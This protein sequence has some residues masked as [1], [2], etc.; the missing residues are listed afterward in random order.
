MLTFFN[1]RLSEDSTVSI[2]EPIKKQNLKTF[3]S[4][5][6][7]KVTKVKDRTIP[8]KAQSDLFGWLAVIMQSRKINLEE[9]FEYPLGPHPWPLTNLTGGLRKTN[10]AALLHKLEKGVD[11]VERDT[12]TSV[13]TII[14]GMAM[15]QKAKTTGLTYEALAKQ[16]LLSVLSSGKSSNR[17]DVVFDQYK[18]RSIKNTERERRGNGQLVVQSIVTTHP[19]QQ[20]GSFLSSWSN[21]KELIR[22]VV[23]QW[24]QESWRSLISEGTMLYVAH[25]SEC[26]CLTCLSVEPVPELCS[27][28]E[29]ADTKM[30]LHAKHASTNGLENILIQSPDTDVFIIALSCLST[31]E[32]NIFFETG[33]RD[34]RRI[35]NLNAIKDALGLK[36]PDHCAYTIDYLLASLLGLHSF[37]GCDS[38]SAFA[39][40]GKA[41][42]LNIMMQS[43]EF[44]TLFSNFGNIDIEEE[45]SQLEKFTCHLYGSTKQNV[46][47]ARYRF[48]CQKQGKLPLSQ[49]P[50][51]QETLRKH[52]Q[53]ANY[54]CRIWRLCL[55]A[56][57]DIN[58]P[59]HHG[60]EDDCDG[61]LVIDWMNC[62]PAPESV[63]CKMI[64]KKI[65][66]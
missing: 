10:K 47:A 12:L 28:Q 52:C 4:M 30:L 40:K 32:G 45:M 65:F 57:P 53:R 20:W 24:K 31:I 60:W 58:N 11:P 7:V 33:V 23:N 49:L 55:E 63:S 15:V 6:K 26:W 1:K 13:S 37:T 51:C 17:I 22:F 44:V 38:V 36:I 21:K 35:I 25:D 56:E 39:G 48:Y 54:Q 19:V 42:A 18:E 59:I 2:Y 8:I 50:P 46:N 61:N 14:D 41:K 43:D 5:T 3:S 9:V 64:Q 62:D 66:V 34:K 29:E 27:S 16:L